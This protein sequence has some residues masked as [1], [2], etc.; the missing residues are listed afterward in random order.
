MSFSEG[1]APVSNEDHGTELGWGFIDT[2]GLFVISPAYTLALNF[3]EGLALVLTMTNGAYDGK[4]IDRHDKAI[5]DNN[6]HGGN[7][8]SQGLAPVSLK[9]Y[10]HGY[11]DKTGKTVIAAAFEEAR[12]FNENFAV[13]RL[14]SDEWGLIDLT[15]KVVL[16]R[17]VK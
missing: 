5:S 14:S 6:C 16:K 9:N 12:P 8:F 7:S 1:L 11:I 3:H 13:V 17:S 15:G 2:K 4:Y 10:K